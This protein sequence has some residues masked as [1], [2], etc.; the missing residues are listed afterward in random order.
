M[1]NES[2]II[3]IRR[4][5]VRTTLTR[6]IKI[7]TALLNESL[8]VSHAIP[9]FLAIGIVSSEMAVI[10]SSALTSVDMVV[11][12]PSVASWLGK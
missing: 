12:V 9:G 4:F 2:H 10:A 6:T 1:P 7:M 3:P 11:S 5:R 8:N